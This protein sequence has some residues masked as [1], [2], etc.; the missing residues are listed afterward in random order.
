MSYNSVPLGNLVS[1]C[2]GK[3]HN[4]SLDFDGKR[5]IQIDDLRNNNN[6]KYTHDNIATEAVEDDLIIAWD[7]ANAG[8][9]GY[10]L[11]G[12]IGSTLARLR[13]KNKQEVFTPYLALYLKSN[14]RGIR[15]NCTGATI[16]H[17]SKQYLTKLQ[18]P[19]PPLETQKQ[20]ATILEKADNLRKQCQQ[21]EQNL[22]ALAQSV[23][24]GMVGPDSP[25]YQSWS[26][27]PIGSLL[28]EKKSAARTGPFG[29][30]LKHSEFVDD[31]VSVLGIDNA[32]NNRFEWNQLRYISAEKYQ[33]LSRYRV[34]PQD[35]LITI[36][37]TTG[38]SAV[39]PDDVPLAIS[40][41]HLA[42]L[43]LNRKVAEPIFISWSIHSHPS[44][45]QQ[46]RQAN[47]GAVMNGLNLGI[48][49]ALEIS[50]PPIEIQKEY[51]KIKSI[52]DNNQKINQRRYRQICKL[53]GSLLEK[54]FNGELDL[55]SIRKFSKTE[56]LE[57]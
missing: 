6:L 49:K 50:L 8:T 12:V 44:V 22:N 47:K 26:K 45:L 24:L 13:P 40:T 21:V 25:A 51:V 19:L 42:T 48:I 15:D 10:G 29:S 39:V 55:K 5:F 11:E 7:G 4:L 43:T 56:M 52:I 17:V 46:I 38:R 54:S 41:K 14:F 33:K 31:G 35:V 53:Y 28:E 23:F 20:I 34:Y 3:K 18:V 27:C 36:M 37:G 2:K 30:D 1:I 32:V 57:R 9:I 16:P